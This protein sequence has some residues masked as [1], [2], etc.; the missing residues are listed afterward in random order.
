MQRY[1]GQA[2]GESAFGG[3]AQEGKGTEVSP[4]S[5]NGHPLCLLGSVW[6]GPW[7]GGGRT[8]GRGPG[9]RGL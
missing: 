5:W 9:T 4:G 2:G 7:G 3:Q 8:G 1:G 6:F